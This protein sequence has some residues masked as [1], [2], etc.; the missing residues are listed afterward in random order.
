VTTLGRVGAWL[1]S[2]SLWPSGEERAAVRTIEDIGYGAV[3]IGENHLNREIFAH[4]ATLLGSTERIVVATGIASIW[5]RD[6]S[7]TANGAAALAE[8]FPGRFVL[9]LGVSHASIVGTRGH[10]YGKPLSAMRDHLDGMAATRYL[11]PAPA[12]P[13][14]LLLAALAPGMMRLAAQRTDGSHPYLVTPAHTEEARATLGPDKILAPEQGIVM[15]DDPAEARR[16]AREHL[17]IYLPWENYTNCWRRLGLDDADFADGGSDRL[18]DALVAWGDE[19]AVA[20]RVKE[21]LDAGATHVPVQALG[22]DPLGQLER[23]APA[24]TGL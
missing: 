17:A 1:G 9:T 21:H 24:L 10:V 20:A 15:L 2:I 6:P 11:A 22:A 12:E 5:A 23:L 14:P 16:A 7:A 13:A 4:A 8:A 19:D 18:V 3:W